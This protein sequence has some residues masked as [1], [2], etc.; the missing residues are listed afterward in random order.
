MIKSIEND[1]AMLTALQSISDREA[2]ILLQ[3]KLS[4]HVNNDFEFFDVLIPFP[5]RYEFSARN[6]SWS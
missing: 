6:E 3:L 2:R 1:A 4:A 5:K